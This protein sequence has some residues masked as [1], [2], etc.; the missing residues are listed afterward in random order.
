[1]FSNVKIKING[2]TIPYIDNYSHMT[3]YVKLILEMGSKMFNFNV[4]QLTSTLNQAHYDDCEYQNFMDETAGFV[5]TPHYFQDT[6]GLLDNNEGLMKRRSLWANSAKIW[7][8]KRLSAYAPF[9]D[10]RYIP[11]GALVEFEFTLAPPYQYFIQENKTKAFVNQ[12]TDGF[13]LAQNTHMTP[14]A[15]TQFTQRLNRKALVTNYLERNATV[16]QV[17]IESKEYR[18]VIGDE[19][20][21]LPQQIHWVFLDED[22]LI[23]NYSKNSY[24]L[25]LPTLLSVKMKSVDDGVFIGT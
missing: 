4:A 20:R 9:A 12:I 25:L 17:P 13:F 16:H 11:P 5:D 1:M 14:A 3:E 19:T 10:Q 2:T 7:T 8:K 6:Y 23:G 18:F 15:L 22:A 24:Q 21:S